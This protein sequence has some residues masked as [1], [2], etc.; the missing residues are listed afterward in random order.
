M[1][2]WFHTAGP[3][4]EDIHYI[5]P[6]TGRLPTLEQLI[7]QRRY[8]VIHAPRQVGKTTAMMALEQQLTQ[9]GQYT[10]AIVSA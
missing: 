4:Q 2:R 9:S 5:L 6:P 3:C 10:A 8:F 7:T 1:P